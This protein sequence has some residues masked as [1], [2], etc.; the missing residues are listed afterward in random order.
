MTV[1]GGL[2]LFPPDAGH[3]DRAD[4]TAS[5]TAVGIDF[6][7]LDDAEIVTRW[8]PFSLPA[9]T[10]GLYQDARRDRAGRPRHR[11]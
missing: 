4:Y 11:G 3:P 6:E 7:L 5:L 8:P 10:V 1:V 9:G 2:D